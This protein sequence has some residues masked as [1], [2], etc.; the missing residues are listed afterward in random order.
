MSH[1][2]KD[3]IGF[4]GEVDTNDTSKKNSMVAS[5]NWR[6]KAANLILAEEKN[7]GNV[8]DDNSDYGLEYEK[9]I[10]PHRIAYEKK[11]ERPT[12]KSNR[13]LNLELAISNNTVSTLGS[14]SVSSKGTTNG[15]N[16]S[17]IVAPNV[18]KL[19]PYS[20]VEIRLQS[21]TECVAVLCSVDVLKMRSMFF[22]QVLKDQEKSR[23]D[24]R[25]KNVATGNTTVSSQSDGIWRDPITVP[26]NSP[27]E[28]ILLIQLLLL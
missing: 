26:E 25:V 21:L 5:T 12:Q 28:G 17:R 7:D 8:D 18:D 3:C 10:S 19:S 9:K 22:H 13:Q 11:N 2:A 23:T 27:F 15:N 4:K 1:L 6:E 24:T 20:V 16:E 14:Q